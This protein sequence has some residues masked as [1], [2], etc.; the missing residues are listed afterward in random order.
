MNYVTDDY[1]NSYLRTIQPHYDGVL[2]EIEKESRDA[3]VPVIPHET[4]RLLS[5]LL[6]MKKPKNILEVGTAVAFSSGLM[7]RYLQDGGTITTIDRY[8]LMLKDAR[9]NIARMG[10]ENTIKI[11]EGDAA[12]ILPTLTGP[13]DVIFLDAAKGQYSA[14]LPHCLRLL[15]VGGLLIVD[16]VLQGGDIAKTR[17]SVPRRQRTIHKRLRNFLWDISHNDALESSIVPI[18]DGLAVC[19]KIKETEEKADIK[20]AADEENTDE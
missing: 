2:G 9:K 14:F 8:E 1:I 7:S 4:A 12:D 10:L 3:Q 19:V 11:L 17:F 5:V 13:Y 20:N 18:G 15:P 16:D 6:T